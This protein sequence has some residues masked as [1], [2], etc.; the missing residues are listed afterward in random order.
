MAV[1]YQD[2]NDESANRLVD[3]LLPTIKVSP[4]QFE[5]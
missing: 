1:E 2:G 5:K 4:E 3:L